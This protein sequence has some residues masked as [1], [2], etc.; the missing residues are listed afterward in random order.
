MAYAAPQCD[1]CGLRAGADRVVFPMLLRAPYA[2]SGTDA[3]YGATR[4]RGFG[5]AKL[6]YGPRTTRIRCYHT[7]PIALRP[8]S[9]YRPKSFPPWTIIMLGPR[10]TSSGSI[11]LL[12]GVFKCGTEL[13]GCGT[14]RRA[15]L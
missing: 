10:G 13:R 4:L 9:P 6:D 15:R 7:L 12:G 8:L 5:I 11:K 3:G 14:T 1:V 2:M